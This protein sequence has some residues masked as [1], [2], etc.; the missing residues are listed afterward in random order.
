MLEKENHKHDLLLQAWSLRIIV[1]SKL[2]KYFLNWSFSG[3]NEWLFYI[4]IYSQA[5]TKE[6]ELRHRRKRNLG[7]TSVC[8]HACSNLETLWLLRFGMITERKEN[9][10]FCENSTT[11]R[12][13]IFCSLFWE[14]LLGR[15]SCQEEGN[16][17]NDF[18][19]LKYTREN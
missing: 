8:S 14:S 13:Y 18:K 5:M 10:K 9:R 7:R 2:L 16:W 6:R 17:S 19:C 3:P 15:N 11:Q 12:R 1:T 4:F